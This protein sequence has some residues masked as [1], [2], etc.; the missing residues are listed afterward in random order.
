MSTQSSD[1]GG[2]DVN[3]GASSG[4][5]GAYVEVTA[6]EAF[7]VKHLAIYHHWPTGDQGYVAIR[8]AIGAQGAEQL[9]FTLNGFSH[10][11]RGETFALIPFAIPERTRI[12]VS[13]KDSAS[14]AKTHRTGIT[15]FD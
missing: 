6:G 3:S 10:A 11:E 12:A 14:G 2:F 7:A 5:F 8:V 9:L 1:R 13:V 15:L 4:E